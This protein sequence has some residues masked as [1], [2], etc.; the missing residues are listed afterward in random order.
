MIHP[1]CLM[2]DLIEFL[3]IFILCILLAN[4]VLI[5]LC[6]LFVFPFKTWFTC[7]ALIENCTNEHTTLTIHRTLLLVTFLDSRSTKLC[8][9]CSTRQESGIR[10]DR[11]L[12]PEA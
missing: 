3:K 9:P 11:H 7:I 1:A 5:P 8:A 12:R 6:Y 2:V 10:R 4:V